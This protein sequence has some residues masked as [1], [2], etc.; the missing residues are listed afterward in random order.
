[1]G[2]YLNPW[3]QVLI[4][5]IFITIGLVLNNK[6]HRSLIRSGWNLFYVV[7]GIFHIVIAVI[8]AVV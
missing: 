5:I 4:G 1:M 3:I 6:S 8:I 2:W 7:W